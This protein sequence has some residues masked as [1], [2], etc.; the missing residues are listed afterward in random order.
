MPG[1]MQYQAGNRGLQ[2][3]SNGIAIGDPYNGNN[4]SDA[5][6]I[7]HIETTANEGEL[8][9]AVGDDGSEMMVARQYNTSN[10]I[11]HQLILMNSAGNM[12]TNQDIFILHATNATMGAY[13]TCPKIVFGE[14]A[15][16]SQGYSQGVALAYTDYD[17]YR[18][19]KGL[20]V[21]DYDSSDGG[22]VWF[23]AQ[24]QMYSKGFN[25]TSSR[26]VKHNIH[27]FTEMGDILDQ[28]E[29]V[30]FEYNDIPGQLRYGLIFEDTI[31][32]LPTICEE[33]GE[34]KTINYVDLVPI[35]LKEI[36]SL[37]RRV[38]KLESSIEKL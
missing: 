25:N 2:I 14:G 23:E 8:E 3:Y 35:L 6:W 13:T 15:T 17:S 7:R 22:N 37:R 5:G 9:I 26:E 1:N 27:S 20:K 21:L 24:G 18:A 30:T 16:A 38:K 10:N 32:I 28:L 33:S 11:A 12:V 31:D 19:S 4:N 36:Q 34:S 29:P